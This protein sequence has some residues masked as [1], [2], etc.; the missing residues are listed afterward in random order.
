MRRVFAL[1]GLFVA[2]AVVA[3]VAASWVLPQAIMY[4]LAHRLASIAGPNT[5]IRP[6]LPDA[7]SREVVMPS[8]DLAYVVCRYDLSDG[9]VRVDVEGLS[10]PYWSVAAYA[11]NTDAFFVVN[12]RTASDN[13]VHLLLADGTQSAQAHDN[14][15]V[16]VA[17]SRTGL[18]LGRIL[19]GNPQEADAYRDQQ[20][21]ISC[22]PA[23]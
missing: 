12:D 5:A 1:A 14:V 10:A 19:V 3:N 20:R 21:K 22:R 9:P 15:R 2:V 6:A 13:G 23:G 18:V 11:A 16:V 17:P 7:S 8:P 4:A